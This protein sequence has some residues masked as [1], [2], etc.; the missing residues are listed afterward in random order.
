MRLKSK[1]PRIAHA[2]V[3]ATVRPQQLL[4][5]CINYGPRGISLWH[6]ISLFASTP[7]PRL[8]PFVSTDDRSLHIKWNLNQLREAS[9]FC[10]SSDGRKFSKENIYLQG[11]FCLRK[12]KAALE[13]IALLHCNLKFW[14]SHCTYRHFGSAN[15]HGLPLQAHHAQALTGAGVMINHCP[16]EA[17]LG[18]SPLL[19]CLSSS[20][21]PRPW[22]ADDV[23]QGALSVS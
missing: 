21:S 17:V 15:A 22:D 18:T 12:T 10:W 19:L 7:P 3:T 8:P 2:V 14:W 13:L 20:A 16:N 1:L 5:N 4:D 23:L 9:P 6:Q 11:L